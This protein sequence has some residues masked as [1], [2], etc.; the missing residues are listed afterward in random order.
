L[1]KDKEFIHNLVSACKLPK[2]VVFI[3]NGVFHIG[4]SLK[5]DELIGNVIGQQE[6]P[7]G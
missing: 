7:F 1:I 5:R 4:P 3:E 2:D 6:V